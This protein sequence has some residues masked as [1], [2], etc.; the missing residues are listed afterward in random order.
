MQTRTKEYC[1]IQLWLRLNLSFVPWEI[2]GTCS[3]LACFLC[4][5]NLGYMY[6]LG[7][8]KSLKNIYRGQAGIIVSYKLNILSKNDEE[9][10]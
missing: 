9:N 3:L 5:V 8:I 1:D 7:M 2:Q 10:G 4:W 6:V